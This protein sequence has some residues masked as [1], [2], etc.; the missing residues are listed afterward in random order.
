MKSKIYYKATRPDGTDF[1]TG[2]VD[3][4]GALV[5]GER[6]SHGSA[7]PVRGDASTYL[8]VSSEP[9]ETLIGGSWPCRLFRVEPS[10]LVAGPS[11]RDRGTLAHKTGCS[12]LY[13]REELPAWRALGPN[14]QAVSE[15]LAGIPQPA[16]AW[17]AAWEAAAQAAACGAAAQAAAWEAAWE[18]AC[19][20][21]RRAAWEV[22][23]DAARG[24][25]WEAAAQAAWEVAQAAA[26]KATALLARDLIT[27]GQFGALS[28]PWALLTGREA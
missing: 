21:A 28:R 23:C 5:S 11:S 12:A 15:F 4:A 13:V 20:A 9:G 2:T 22:A 17:E 8:S 16:A 26:W 14:G 27:E 1:H 18:A 24:A 6:V 19:D 10:G 7:R 25:A 3:Y